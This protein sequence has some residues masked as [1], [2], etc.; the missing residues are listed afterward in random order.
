MLRYLLKEREKLNRLGLFLIGLC[1]S[2][3]LYAGHPPTPGTPPPDAPT[4]NVPDDPNDPCEGS[5]S[6][7]GGGGNAGAGSGSGTAGKPVRL[8]NG[9]ER[10]RR[11]DLTVNGVFPIQIIRKY[12][13]QST[14]DTPLG[15]GW[16]FMHDRQLYEFANGDVVIRNGCGRRDKILYSG[17]AYVPQIGGLRGVLS[18]QGDGSFIFKYLNGEQDFYDTQGRLV[19]I[20]DP[21]GNRHEFIY[22]LAGKLPLIGA[23]PYGVDPGKPI[24]VASNYR[25]TRIEE[26][27]ADGVLSM[28]AVDFAYDATTGRLLSVTADDD[29]VVSYVHDQTPDSLTLG[30]LETVNG[31]DGL[32]SSYR[33]D[34]VN[35]GDIHNITS[36]QEGSTT[37]YVNQY[38][39][40][41]RVFQQTRGNNNDTLDI[42]YDIDYQQT[43]VTHTITD[44]AGQTLNTLVTQYEFDTEGYVTRVSDDVGT[45]KSYFYEHPMKWRTRDEVSQ[46]EADGVTITLL[47][48]R[49]YTYTAS[50]NKETEVMTLASG[51]VNTKTWAYDNDWI[52]SEQTVSS[53]E[54]TKIFRTD[55]TFYYDSNGFPTNIKEKKARK[56]DG[57]FQITAYTYNANGRLETTTLP[58]AHVITNVY[59]GAYLIRIFQDDGTGGESPYLK[60]EYGYDAQGNR[61]RITDANGNITSMVYDDQGRITQITNALNEET[62][63][64]YTDDKLTQIEVGRTAAEGAGQITQLIYTQEG[65]LETIQRQNDSGGW[66]T[67]LTYT[68]DSRGKPLSLIEA[69]NGSARITYMEHDALGRLTKVTDPANNVTQYAYDAM[70]NR[71][72][73]IDANTNET[74]YAYDALSRLT[75]TTQVGVTSNPTTKFTYDAVGNLTS[76]TDAKN[77][78]TRYE[79]DTLSNNT[80]VVQPLGQTVRYAYD[81]RNRVDYLVN[82]RG[83]KIDYNYFS[84]GPVS[85]VR[86]YADETTT[87]VDRTVNYTYHNTGVLNSIY[88]NS[89]PSLFY[90]RSL[91]KL[92]RVLTNYMMGVGTGVWRYFTYAYDQYGNRSRISLSQYENGIYRTKYSY[93]YTYNKLNRLQSAGLIN[94]TGMSFIY[95]DSGAP[96]QIQHGN[97]TT[98]DYTYEANGPVRQIKVT[99][100]SEQLALNTYAYDNNRNVDT[101]QTL[102][103]LHDYTYDGLNR[104]TQALHP[105]GSG[106]IAQEDFSYDDV[107]NREDSG[108][109]SLW[110]YDA[111]NRITNSIGLTYNFDNDGN[112]LSRSDGATF[113]YDHENRLTDYSDGASNASY[114]YDPFGRRVKKI[115]G[116]VSTWYLWDGDKLM[117]EYGDSGNLLK[118]YAYLPGNY[119]PSQIADGAGNVYT[120]HSDHLDTP[121]QM[122]DSA[123]KVVWLAEHTAYGESTPNEDVDGDGT[124]VTLN[125]RYPGQYYDSETGLHYNYFRYYDPKIGRYITADP[126]GLRAGPNVYTYA[127]NNPIIYIDPFGL[128]CLTPQQ[129]EALAAMMG[130]AAGG[131]VSGMMEGAKWGGI[132][133]AVAMGIAGSVRGAGVAMMTTI[134]T[135]QAG[136]VAGAGSNA[137]TANSG[138]GGKARAGLGTVAGNMA[139]NAVGGGVA[140]AAAAGAVGGAVSSDPVSGMVGGAVGGVAGAVAAKMIQAGNDCGGDDGCSQ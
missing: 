106:L 32:V 91:D 37:P 51:E 44:G 96:K 55:Y 78:T 105:T 53:S 9:A 71:T 118:R 10:F 16:A 131:A 66:L 133:G 87:T 65:W 76:V 29:R 42:T 41:D 114:I 5:G 135:Q 58:D 39:T 122:T 69:D 52:K 28:R 132:P 98:T 84:W 34:G 2:S 46:L 35:G 117:G 38:D 110:G 6:G 45:I 61:N 83:Q 89:V 121:K 64:T 77:Q 139:L 31:L 81:D 50:G 127:S 40:R 120:V 92:N 101:L 26:R 136:M 57:S 25:L 47:R 23:S 20:A 3:A 124:T 17:G 82:A 113:T 11:T 36:I 115:I 14:Y 129:I 123:G 126:I 79:Y 125:V 21:R 59:T 99:G 56:N 19:A 4:E 8:F 54:P 138:A 18:K 70:G 116:G 67:L 24:T 95:Y 86:Y 137:A 111:N 72:S 119:A 85:I 22:D 33:Y 134:A 130:G 73:L 48:E 97:G 1:L 13:S 103:G 112:V 12:D 75:Q 107:G 109:P 140:G 60:V 68:Y 30:N 94:P 27:T 74:R 102:V 80:A 104:L 90:F 88:D 7:A 43:T 62:H 63:Y 15:F 100:G 49:D 108:D 93:N 128:Y